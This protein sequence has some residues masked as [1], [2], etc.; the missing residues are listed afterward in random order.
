MGRLS[1]GYDNTPGTNTVFFMTHDKITAIPKDRVV[2][3]ARIVVDY[4]PQKE[5]PN[6]ARITAGENLIDYPYELTTRTA[7]LTTSKIV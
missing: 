1:Q 6:R 4:R 2:T 5:D 3:Y 7:D